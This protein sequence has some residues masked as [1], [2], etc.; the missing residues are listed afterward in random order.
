MIEALN[1]SFSMANGHSAFNNT[2][3][4]LFLFPATDFTW[5]I[6]AEIA[7]VEQKAYPG[8]LI[9]AAF[10]HIRQVGSNIESHPGQFGHAGS[11]FSSVIAW[12]R[13]VIIYQCSSRYHSA[14]VLLISLR[15][16]PV[17]PH[18][19][20]TAAR[21]KCKHFHILRST[22]SDHFLFPGS[23]CLPL[24]LPRIAPPPASYHDLSSS[25]S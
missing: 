22:T 11:L 15:P 4:A 21:T 9:E 7:A 24:A 8:I 2:N 5:V 20:L 13:I 17:L 10:L 16:F 19:S 25:S 18:A 14:V 6:I 23:L 3:Y 1:S 12:D